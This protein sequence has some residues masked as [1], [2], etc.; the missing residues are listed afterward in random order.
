MYA[1]AKIQPCPDGNKRLGLHVLSAF[2]KLNGM[3]LDT[4]PG[5]LAA[6]ILEVAAT[7]RG[8]QDAVV[9]ELTA[10]LRVKLVAAE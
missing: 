9:Q 5:E 7:D 10:W 3:G 2:L 4:Q 1:F 6:K 8:V